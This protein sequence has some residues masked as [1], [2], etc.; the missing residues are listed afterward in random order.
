MR[1]GAS[2]LRAA[3]ALDAA[4]VVA[5][6][7]GGGKTSAL[8]RL[9]REL[10]PARVLV[11]T[12]TRIWRP[13]APDTPVQLADTVEHAL[14]QLADWSAGIRVLGTSISPEGKLVGIPPEWVATLRAVADYLLVEADGAAGKPLT[15]PRSYEPVIPPA[16]ELVVPIAGADAVGAPLDAAHVHRVEELCAL[17]GVAPGTVLSPSLIARVLL[18]P[19][20][21]VRGAPPGARLVP[22]VNKV[23]ISERLAPAQAV[24]EAL[25]AQGAER[26]VLAALARQ[27]PVVE[28]WTREQPLRPVA[29]VL[30]AAG[31]STRLGRPKQLLPYGGRPLLRHVAETGLLAGLAPL[32][33]V[34]GP[35]PEAMRAALTGLPVQVVENPRY[36]EGQSTSVRAGV[37][38]LPPTTPAVVMLLVDM[39]GVTPAV[40][41][42]LIDA[43][44]ATG[45]PI[46]RPQHAGQPGNPVLFDGH[47]LG[48]LAAVEGD[49]GGR[50]VLRRHAA[51][52]HLLSV[53]EPGVVVDIDT[54]EAYAALLA[55]QASSSGPGR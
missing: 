21:N 55:G 49:E 35:Q 1:S 28:C 31:L 6:T 27:P 14:S 44:R 54:W 52:T 3:L 33:V 45:A 26:V 13:H 39:P 5:F 32:V 25:L 17:L 4:R 47:L 37:A 34:L 19:N 2:T 36:A 16:T 38:A 42:A 22:L 18:A 40:I 7:G 46:V 43:W 12:T 50:A 51:R 24:A 53:A 23:D 10:A 30:L 9:A 29:G 41:R 11:T 8:F 20:G 48:E 15:A